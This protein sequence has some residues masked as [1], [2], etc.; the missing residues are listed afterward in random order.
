MAR[1]WCGL[2]YRGD[3][4]SSKYTTSKVKW[5]FQSSIL[6]TGYADRISTDMESNFKV[7]RYVIDAPAPCIIHSIKRCLFCSFFIWTAGFRTVHHDVTPRDYITNDCDRRVLREIFFFFFFHDPFQLPLNH[8][9]THSTS[10]HP[11]SVFVFSYNILSFSFVV[12]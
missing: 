11:V 3:I 2:S 7:A 1:T 4:Y 9:P 8:S 12:F 10:L 6:H 5:C